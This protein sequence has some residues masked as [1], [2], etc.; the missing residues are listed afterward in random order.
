MRIREGERK[1]KG[2][3]KKKRT[4]KETSKPGIPYGPTHAVGRLA[5]SLII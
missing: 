5:A 3:G 4:E 2:K 1:R